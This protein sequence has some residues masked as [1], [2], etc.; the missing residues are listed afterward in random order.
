MSRDEVLA[1][2]Q[3]VR[4]N[5]DAL[6]GMPQATFNEFAADPRNLPATL[7]LLQ[8]AIQAL[9]D[10]GTVSCSRL[11]LRTPRSSH[12]VFVALGQTS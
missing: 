5:L 2:A 3:T 8:T 4:E 6:D 12:D 7:H 11:G 10:I 1:K 9:I